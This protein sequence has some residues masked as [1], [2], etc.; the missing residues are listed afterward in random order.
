MLYTADDCE[1]PIT[2][3]FIEKLA[4]RLN[5]RE[6]KDLASDS[7]AMEDDLLRPLKVIYSYSPIKLEEI[8]LPSI[9][10]LDDVMEKI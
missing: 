4:K 10:K 2:P 1:P 7:F 3:E 6:S 8:E 5:E 9:L